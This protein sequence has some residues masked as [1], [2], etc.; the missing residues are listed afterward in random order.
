MRFQI[1]YTIRAAI[2]A[3]LHQSS[4]ELMEGETK[5]SIY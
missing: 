3:V 5:E 2:R 1:E 4:W